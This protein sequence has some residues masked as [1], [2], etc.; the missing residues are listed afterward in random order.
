MRNLGVLITY[1]SPAVTSENTFPKEIPL[2]P[3]GITAVGT[4]PAAICMA[5]FFDEVGTNKRRA[6]DN[7]PNPPCAKYAHSYPAPNLSLTCGNVVI[8]IPATSGPNALVR[9][10]ELLDNAIALAIRSCATIS[11]IN[12]VRAGIPSDVIAP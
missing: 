2:M 5:R 6:T 3:L 4:I 9:F 10:I 7:A 8:K 1:L 11:A 12:G